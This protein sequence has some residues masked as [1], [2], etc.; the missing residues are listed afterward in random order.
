MTWR[1]RRGDRTISHTHSQ[2]KISGRME[3]GI[4]QACDRD[5]LGSS[6][7]DLAASPAFR[8]V[9]CCNPGGNLGNC[10][11][12]LKDPLKGRYTVGW[13]AHSLPSLIPFGLPG[14]GPLAIINLFVQPSMP[15]VDPRWPWC[16]CDKP[17]RV[18]STQ[19]YGACI[20]E[21]RCAT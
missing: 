8:V 16:G 17:T 19:E 2:V 12:W 13:S 21:G 18:N 7:M 6:H 5:T 1:I 3:Y 9:V 20:R 15:P 4:Y 10:S 11:V 14:A